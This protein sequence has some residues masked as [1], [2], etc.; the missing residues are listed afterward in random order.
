MIFYLIGI[1]V[2][3][4][5]AALLKITEL[6]KKNNELKDHYEEEREEYIETL[7]DYRNTLGALNDKILEYQQREIDL[8]DIVDKDTHAETKAE[9]EKVREEYI[10]L[11]NKYDSFVSKR[12]SSEVKLGAIAETL[13]PFLEGFPYN[14]KNLRSLG[15]PIDYV[16]FEEEEVTFIEVK[17]GESK[18]SKR[19]RDIQKLVEEGKV[20]FEIHR[21]GEKGLKVEEQK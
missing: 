15:S 1:L 12:K 5:L 18:L 17:S 8:K 21:I 9:L 13:T 2:I 19:Q 7:E 4:C 14:P 16:S 6:S 3:L 11:K 10:Q 20:K